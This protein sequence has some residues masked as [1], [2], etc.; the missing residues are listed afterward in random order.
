MKTLLNLIGL[1][2]AMAAVAEETR[3]DL[4]AHEWGTF[5]AVVGSDGREVPWWS[6]SVE[7]ASALPEFVAP[8]IG[9]ISK[10]GVG[11]WLLRMETPVI[12]FYA[13]RSADLRVVV[14]DTQVKVTEAY[15]DALFSLPRF[16]EGVP[17]TS[18][19]E[20][21]IGIRPPDDEIG[22]QMPEVGER[23]AHYRHAREVPEAWWVVGHGKKQEKEV[24]K[25]IFYRGAGS[26]M[27]P[28]RVARV[29]EQGVELLANRLPLY[30]V[31]VKTGE[32]KWK[33]VVGKADQ[34]SGEASLF[35]WPTQSQDAESGAE[36]L[37]AA[38]VRDLN[39]EGLTK[40]EAQAMVDTWRDAW[41]GEV[42]VRVLELLPRRWVDEVLPLSITPKPATVERVFVGR[43]ELLKEETEQSVIA[44]MDE[45]LPDAMRVSRLRDLN[46]GRFLNA[47]LERAAV[48]RD[49]RFRMLSR[50]ASSTLNAPAKSG[51]K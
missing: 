40:D 29:V 2:C 16:E 46:L 14:D 21:R 27:M 15:P 31:E 51:I 45:G 23:G 32:L 7:G 36:G 35:Y 25:F 22:K 13:E 5:T 47:A 37:A 43:W 3:E 17:R 33:R 48:V 39:E 34:E 30:L 44:A 11:L 12:Y 41:L 38:L 20:W 49:A 18:F 4:M 6:Q 19:K 8:V 24:E 42:G 50:N 10:S 26:A 1:G 9:P 28:K